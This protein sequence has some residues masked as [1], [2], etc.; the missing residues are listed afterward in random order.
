MIISVK[1]STIIIGEESEDLADLC[2]I[3]EKLRKQL[4]KYHGDET[5]REL[6]ASAGRLAFMTAE[7]IDEEVQKMKRE[8]E[9][10]LGKI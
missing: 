3:I 6:I 5:A 1:D 7:E 9:E 8:A 2:S 4:T 10:T